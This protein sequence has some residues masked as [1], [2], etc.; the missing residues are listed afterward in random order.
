MANEI[1]TSKKSTDDAKKRTEKV[2][3]A[4]RD[5][6]KKVQRHIEKEKPGSSTDIVDSAPTTR[7]N[8]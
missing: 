7:P 5:A 3:K 8:D 2:P 4:V 1:P 6:Q